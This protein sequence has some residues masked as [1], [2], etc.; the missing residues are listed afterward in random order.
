MI[1]LAKAMVGNA[2]VYLF[3]LFAPLCLLF[4]VFFLFLHVYF[5]IMCVLWQINNNNNKLPPIYEVDQRV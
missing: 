5:M 2:Y 3:H 4:K 1:H